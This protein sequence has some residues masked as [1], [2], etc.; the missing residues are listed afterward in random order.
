MDLHRLMGECGSLYWGDLEF[1]PW[2]GL[3]V[4]LGVSSRDHVDPFSVPTRSMLRMSASAVERVAAALQ[5][6]TDAVSSLRARFE[7][8]DGATRRVEVTWQPIGI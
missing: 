8:I 1:S 7:K 4:P 3:W 2:E 5:I 6:P